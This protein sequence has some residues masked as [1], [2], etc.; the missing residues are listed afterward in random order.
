MRRLQEVIDH[1]VPRTHDRGE[2]SRGGEAAA[3]W[4]MLIEGPGK[5]KAIEGLMT[6]SALTPEWCGDESHEQSLLSSKLRV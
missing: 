6:T 1:D 3:T 2:R 4:C 5:K